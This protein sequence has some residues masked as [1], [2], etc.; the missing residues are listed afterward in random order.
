MLLLDIENEIQF[1]FHP[2]VNIRDFEWRLPAAKH[3]TRYRAAI[4]VAK[5]GEITSVNTLFR[6]TLNP[7]HAR[8]Q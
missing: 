1:H 6:F 7:R 5:Y 2:S 8:F 4:A 3:H